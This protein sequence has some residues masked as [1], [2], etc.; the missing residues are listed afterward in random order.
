MKKIESESEKNGL[1]YLTDNDIDVLSVGVSTGGEAEI[2]MAKMLDTR[3]V[4]A[5]TI[6]KNGYESTKQLVS[7]SG[8]ADRIEIK[9]ED[10]SD[11]L[12]Y[13]E[14]AFD[15]IYA[16]LVLHY[17]PKEKLNHAVRG[18]YRVTKNNGRIFVVVR[19]VDS[20][21]AKQS[22]NVY[23]P[24]TCMTTYA[25]NDGNTARRYFHTKESITNVL[26]AHGWVIENTKQYD[27]MLNIAYDRSDAWVKNNV[28]EVLAIKRY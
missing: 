11:P 28:I 12:P 22:D 1:S 15:Y 21:E 9:F 6:D 13:S 25:N 3:S 10:V 4:T 8:L 14:E 20:D 19:S 5:T 24:E 17:L 2:K 16:R 23:D 7:E 18:L 27:E 26:E